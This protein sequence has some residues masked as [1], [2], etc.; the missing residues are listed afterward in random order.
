M[1]TYQGG[2]MARKSDGEKIDELEKLAATLV[3]RVDNVRKEL[4]EFKKSIEE[5]SRRRWSI[6]PSIIGAFVGAI[7]G[8]LAQLALL[9]LKK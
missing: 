3:E 9:Q 5:A 7:L 2:K 8:F 1:A 4:D 6:W